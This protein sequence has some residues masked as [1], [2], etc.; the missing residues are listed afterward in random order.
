[1]T[2]LY[3][4]QCPPSR[5]GYFWRPNGKGYTDNPIE[6]GIWTEDAL[7]MLC[8]RSGDDAPDLKVEALP[9]LRAAAEA[10]HEALRRA[11]AAVAVAEAR[12]AAMEAG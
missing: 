11:E 9:L 12:V 1:M 5:G 8:G 3:F 6:A 2:K 4:I 10:S 7:P